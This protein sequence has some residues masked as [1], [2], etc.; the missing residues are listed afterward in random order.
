MVSLLYMKKIL[1]AS[2]CILTLVYGAYLVLKNSTF[3]QRPVAVKTQ[4]ETK[5]AEIKKIEIVT[6]DGALPVN[7]PIVV[8]DEPQQ[9]FPP[10]STDLTGPKLGTQ[11]VPSTAAIGDVHQMY[12][13]HPSDALFMTVTESDGLRALWRLDANGKAERVMAASNGGGDLAIFND[14][15]GNLY[16]QHQNPCRLYRSGDGFK[17]WREVFQSPCMF[18][19]MADDGKGTVYATLH[20]WNSALL[21]RSPDGGFSW[22]PWKDFQKI[23]PEYAVPYAAND[24]RFKLRHLH[25]VL[26]DAANQ[27]LLVGTGDVARF[28]MESR[29]NGDT[30][31]QVWD[32][33]FTAHLHIGRDRYLLAPDQLHSHGIV[34]YDAQ[35]GTTKDV[36]DPK[37]YGYAGYI[38]SMINVDGIYYA[39]IHT[40]SNE[41]DSVVPKFGVIV[42]PNG[43]NWYRFLEWGPLTHHA[44]TD[45][46]LAAAPGEIYAAVNG[47]LYAFRPLDKK[48][49]VEKKPFG[50][51]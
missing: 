33:G 4:L 23:L 25:D 26:Y 18:W 49:F 45:V 14:S 11:R 5:V 3:F 38:Y 30:W 27:L 40:E 47:A 8:V 37:T 12:F 32:E 39:A 10:P 7:T 48:W 13:H 21:F 50:K 19:A 6:N 15:Q 17:T 42:S 35:K 43:E 41:V 22:E 46:M 24:D 36:W 20:D 31:H 9:Y 29:D 44:R 1:L 16:F 51:E 2:L 28:A 34:L